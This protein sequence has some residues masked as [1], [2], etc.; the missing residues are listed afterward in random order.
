MQDMTFLLFLTS[1]TVGEE[2]SQP[3]PFSTTVPL[4]LIFERFPLLY[5]FITLFPF[6]PVSSPPRSFIFTRDVFFAT[7]SMSVGGCKFMERVLL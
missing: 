1:N 4:R 7:E 5:F 2:A 6:F 3:P